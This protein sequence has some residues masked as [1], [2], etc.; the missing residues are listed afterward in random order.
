MIPNFQPEDRTAIQLGDTSARGYTLRKGIAPALL[1]HP[2]INSHEK[3]GH[4]N[5]LNLHPNAQSLY[6]L[7]QLPKLAYFCPSSIGK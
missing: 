6:A 1:P 5:A 7:G 3:P 2:A 4:T